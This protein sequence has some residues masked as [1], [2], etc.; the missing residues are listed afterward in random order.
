M[1][2]IAKAIVYREISW[3]K[4]F[5]PDYVV[6]WI[7]PL[8]FSLGVVFLPATLSS[9][10]AVIKNMSILFGVEMDLKTAYS[11]A[12]ILT[13][14]INVVAMTVND[15]MQTLFAEFRFMEVGSMI[16]EATS[17]VKYIALNAILRPLLMTP[18]ATVYMAPLLLYLNGIDGFTEFL[19]VEAILVLT[20]V[21]L[22]LYATI[23]A[24]PLTFHT[25]VSRP[26][27][28]ANIL[29][30]AILAGTGIYIPV[31]LVPLA[32]RLIALT[33]PVPET[34]KVLYVIASKG[35][36]QVLLTF[37]AVLA[38]FTTLYIAFSGLLSKSAEVRVRRG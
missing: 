10:T 22:G 3:F 9:P 8:A 14:I 20:S 16:L 7:L 15:V 18:L 31:E 6:S 38:F 21:V 36:S 23:F 2:N 24:I 34:C 27:T 25:S 1:L 35:F 32:L 28:I 30:P 5:L 29:A 26:W 11:I 17:L 12:L 13:G 33:T 19:I 4:R 37:G